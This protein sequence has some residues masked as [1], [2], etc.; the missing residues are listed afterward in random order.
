MGT[1]TSGVETAGPAGPPERNAV[2]SRTSDTLGPDLYTTIVGL[3]A[4][5]FLLTTGIWALIAPQSFSDAVDWPSHEHYL[6]DVGAFQIGLGIMMLLALVWRDTLAIALTAFVVSNTIHAFNHWSDLEL[7]GRAS[8]SPLLGALSV[9]GVVVLVRRARQLG[10][11][12]GRVCLTTSPALAPYVYQKTVSLTTFRKSGA[13]VATPVNLAVEGDVA[14]FRTY[15][16]AGKVKRLR[17][18]QDVAVAPSRASGEVTGPELAGS[19]RRLDGEAAARAAHLIRRKYPVQ[20][21][22]LVPLMHRLLRAK[23]GKTLHFALT[24]TPGE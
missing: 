2:G 17:R 20:Q 1:S 7:G 21:G 16:K 15:E 13:P 10:Y 12:W 18:N 8:D 9:A 23:T 4:A 19:A 6:H 14:Y 3:L 24:P 5:G 11:V 22:L